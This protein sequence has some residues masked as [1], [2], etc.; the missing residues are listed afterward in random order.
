MNRLFYLSYHLDLLFLHLQYQAFLFR[1]NHLF[2]RKCRHR[3]VY[4]YRRLLYHCHHRLV[5][6]VFHRLFQGKFH[7][8]VVYYLFFFIYLSML[9]S[10][11]FSCFWIQKSIR[12]PTCFIFIINNFNPLGTIFF[13]VCIFFHF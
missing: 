7:Q 9:N 13:V 6:Y 3:L 4:Q 2:R 8:H 10:F 1:Q 11:S 12:N 5:V